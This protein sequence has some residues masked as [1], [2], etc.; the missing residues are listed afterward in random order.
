MENLT[1][2]P[3]EEPAFDWFAWAI[4]FWEGEGSVSRAG[5][6]ICLNAGQKDEEPLLRL[7]QAFGGNVTGP[8]RTGS[9]YQWSISSKGAAELAIRIMPHLSNRRQAQIIDKSPQHL[10]D[11]LQQPPGG[12]VAKRLDI[13]RPRRRTYYPWHEWLDG[14]TWQALEGK[15][16]TCSIANFQCALH[17]KAREKG[18]DVITG[19]PVKGVVEFRFILN[20][21]EPANA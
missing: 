7:A 16:F 21:T 1:D 4:G 6:Y 15:D 12:Y 2:T 14:S 11:K 5:A 19:S 20:D 8:Y 3:P 10:R 9:R 18:I 17:I 13:E